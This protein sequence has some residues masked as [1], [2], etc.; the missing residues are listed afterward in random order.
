MPRFEHPK[1]FHGASVPVARHDDPSR[2]DGAEPLR[3]GL[4][5]GNGRLAD[6]NRPD[7]LL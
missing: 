1:P 6:R 4:G 3:D 5:H 2:Q 7:V